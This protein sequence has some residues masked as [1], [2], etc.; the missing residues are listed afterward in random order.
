[1]IIMSVKL[2][3]IE[4]YNRL[5]ASRERADIDRVVF[6]VYVRHSYHKLSYVPSLAKVKSSRL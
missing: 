3:V 4:A 5:H 6:S 1:M 2:N